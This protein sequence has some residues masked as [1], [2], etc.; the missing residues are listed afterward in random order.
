M[1][2]K[3][4]KIPAPRQ[5]AFQ[6]RGLVRPP[7]KAGWERMGLQHHKVEV[8]ELLSYNKGNTVHIDRA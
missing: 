6:G 4:R 7:L 2:L 5:Q 3:R 8:T 1:E